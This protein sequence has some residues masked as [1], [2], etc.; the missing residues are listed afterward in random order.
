MNT[1]DRRA[2]VSAVIATLLVFAFLTGFLVSKAE[3]FQ[4]AKESLLQWL[5]FD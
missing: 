1:S 3:W 2:I 4:P 5:P